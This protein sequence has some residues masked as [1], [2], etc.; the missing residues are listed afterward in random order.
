MPPL[1]ALK[2]IES[3]ANGVDPETG[4]ILPTQS[5]F[6]NPQIIRALF[7][8]GKALDKAAKH[9]ERNNSLPHKAGRPWSE[10]EDKE[11]IALFDVGTQSKVI[12]E[13]HARTQGAVAARLIRLGKIKDRFEIDAAMAT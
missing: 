10:E 6:N 8:A 13:K 7:V 5:I 1:E 4:E 3:L 9:A 11:L 2:I 12:A